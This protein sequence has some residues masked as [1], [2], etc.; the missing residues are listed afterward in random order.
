MSSTIQINN[1]GYLE[2]EQIENWSA[3]YAKKAIA[4]HRENAVLD[5]PDGS[6]GYDKLDGDVRS[7]LDIAQKDAKSALEIV[8]AASTSCMEVSGDA[9]STAISAEDIAT[10]AKADVEA[11]ILNSNT[12]EAV[13]RAALLASESASVTAQ[14]VQ[15]Q[16]PQKQDKEPEWTLLDNVTLTED[17][18]KYEFNL[19][20]AGV[21]CGVKIIIEVPENVAVGSGKLLAADE[22]YGWIQDF[23]TTAYSAG[24]NR[25]KIITASW[26]P[27]NGVFEAAC[28]ERTGGNATAGRLLYHF[29]TDLYKATR[30]PYVRHQGSLY[31]GTKIKVWGLIR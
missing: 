7:R 8:K 27:R 17:I 1:S 11:A 3:V 10:Q 24:T 19:K 5:H 26:L 18:Q 28:T 30:I 14:A 25:S 29:N 9:L 12:A 20:S 22:N 6:V 15:S 31:T 16:L 21:V 23:T 2:S 13:S 4:D